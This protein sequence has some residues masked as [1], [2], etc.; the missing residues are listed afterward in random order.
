MKISEL[1][2]KTGL[3]SHTIRY[4]EKIFLLKP[5]KRS[6]NSYR[7]YDQNAIQVIDFI[8]ASKRLGFKLNEIQ[9][10]INQ[11]FYDEFNFGKVRSILEKKC[12]EIDNE[13]KNLSTLKIQLMNLMNTCP[14]NAIISEKIKDV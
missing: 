11:I 6:D 14:N 10:Y 1:S 9:P 8:R 13:I 3:S 4:Y 2:K 7:E 12:E 5:S